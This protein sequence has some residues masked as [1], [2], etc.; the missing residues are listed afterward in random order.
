M[1]FTE[2]LSKLGFCSQKDKQSLEKDIKQ[3]TE[4]LSEIRN[5]INTIHK[6]QENKILVLE[7]KL[8]S[9]EENQQKLCLNIA[10]RI[11]NLSKFVD[12]N[13]S[14]IQD[15]LSNNIIEIKNAFDD[16]SFKQN[17]LIQEQILSLK[18]I[19][20]KNKVY[21]TKALTSYNDN[22]SKIQAQHEEKFN[23]ILNRLSNILDNQTKQKVIIA[24]KLDIIKKEI[25]TASENI[26]S[27]QKTLEINSLNQ[28]KKDD[29]YLIE[30]LLRLII[31]NK[32]INDITNKKG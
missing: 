28:L 1:S 13:L 20:Q 3:N 22:L 26:T 11:E 31:A 18:K 16:N 10:D 23:N 4:I 7:N 14:T 6:Q 12:N 25:T 32:F 8:S 27:L 9:I 19:Q 29:L 5:L 30:D 15:N 2:I 21:I 17:N 24:N